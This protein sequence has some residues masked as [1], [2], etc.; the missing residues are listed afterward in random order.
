MEQASWRRESGE[1]ENDGRH[2]TVKQNESS[3]MYE[4]NPKVYNVVL[5]HTGN[6]SMTGIHITCTRRQ[7]APKEILSLVMDFLDDILQ[8]ECEKACKEARYVV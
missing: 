5:S 7:T 1:D 2:L 8:F 3:T 6:E 4:G